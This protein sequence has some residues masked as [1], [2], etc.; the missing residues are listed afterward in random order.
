MQLSDSAMRNEL[1][2]KSKS[3]FGSRVGR[4]F[5]VYHEGS[6]FVGGSAAARFYFVF[7]TLYLHFPE[8]FVLPILTGLCCNVKKI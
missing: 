8:S 6:R 3:R 1:K 2:K 5:L 7:V 4:S